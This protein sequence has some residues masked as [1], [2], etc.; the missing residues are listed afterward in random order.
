MERTMK[1]YVKLFLSVTFAVCLCVLLY[2]AY[3]GWKSA[4]ANEEALQIA[5]MSGE[6]ERPDPLSEEPEQPD[7][8][9]EEP[10]L[11]PAES[12]PE[13]AAHLARLNLA[14]LQAVNEDVIGWLEI[15]G[16]EISYPVL[17]GPDN[18]FYLG[19][20]WKR[21]P[22]R[23]GSVFL[24]QT[25]SRD[26]TGFH[27]IVYAHRKRD[28]TMF[29]SLKYYSEPEYCRQ[30]P[31]IY[32]VSEDSVRRYEVFAA[33][34]AGVTSMVY[35]LDLE[36]R[37]LEEEFLDFCLESSEIDTGVV[38][39][40]DNQVLTLSTCTGQGY[41]SRWVVQGTL[42]GQYARASAGD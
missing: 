8:P 34:K 1:R 32:L 18:E 4:G 12:L 23:S 6:P 38:P 7:S 41:S 27:L 5:G 37:G 22:S 24:E 2:R 9:S 26:L 36:E 28:G 25:N 15:P 30:H 3:D 35:R 39:E 13:E 33:Y 16:T 14:A 19:H 10:G 11:L 21:E 17:Q 42:R 29:G 31:A 20:N 40:P